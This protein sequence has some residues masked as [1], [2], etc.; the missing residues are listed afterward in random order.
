I[1]DTQRGAY[2]FAKE[3]MPYQVAVA[4]GELV[5]G[6]VLPGAALKTIGSI[7]RFATTARTAIWLARA[8]AWIERARETSTAI[9]AATGVIRFAAE[10]KAAW[11]AFA[12]SGRLAGFAA[13]VV[14][15]YTIF[16]LQK[17]ATY[18][19]KEAGVSTTSFGGKLLY[20]SIQGIGASAQNRIAR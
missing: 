13:K 16:G 15:G 18:L 3:M 9:K 17:G 6:I 7:G 10:S 1:N 8:G 20:F 2:A 4:G 14:E 19:A 12:Q 11:Q 5:L